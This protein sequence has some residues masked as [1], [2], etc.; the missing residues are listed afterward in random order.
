MLVK[1]VLVI[2]RVKVAE[3]LLVS[4]NLIIDRKGKWERVY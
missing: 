1:N 2:D 3:L 4:V